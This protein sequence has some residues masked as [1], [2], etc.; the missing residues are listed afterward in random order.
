MDWS[1]Y[2]HGGS[3][4]KVLRLLNNNVVIVETKEGQ[5][6]VVCGK[7]IAFNKRIGDEI[8]EEKVNKIFI[9]ADSGE[10]TQLQQFI[11]EIPVDLIELAAD[12]A[13]LARLQLGK[14]IDDKI[15]LSLSDHIHTSIQRFLDGNVLTNSMLWEIKRFYEPEYEIGKQ[16]LT[17]IEERFK[18]S[19]PKDEAG[20]I[21]LHIA[22]AEMDGGSIES[23]YEISKIIQDIS[24]IVHYH[25]NI[26][27][28]TKSIYFYRFITH[29]KFFAQRLILNTPSPDN[30][31]DD[32]FIMIKRK[33]Y[34]AYEC[35]EKIEKYLNKNYEY[36]FSQGEKTYLTIH[37]ENIVEKTNLH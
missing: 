4:M 7:G 9:Q 20:F 37:I 22:E 11:S 27:F 8:D 16:V 23:V 30:G 36:Y 26:E 13:K 33:Y 18:I 3:L 21:A 35:V 2:L 31:D 6:Q 28:D 34:N 29:L 24:N 5:E 25:F 19:L 15:I 1:F 10:V 17:M 14:K 12:V 32:L